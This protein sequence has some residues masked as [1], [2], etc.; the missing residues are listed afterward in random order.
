MRARIDYDRDFPDTPQNRVAVAEL[1][2]LISKH[3]P[4]AT[5]R[6][7][8]SPEEPKVI[9]L[10]P[11]VD[12]IDTDEVVDLV[13]DRELELQ[14]EGVPIHVIPLRTPERNA[15]VRAQLAKARTHFPR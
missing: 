1:A 9:H 3:Y 13:I 6:V 14:D 11:V 15:E 5:F 8:A 10:Y 4:E 12:L 2:E 7:S